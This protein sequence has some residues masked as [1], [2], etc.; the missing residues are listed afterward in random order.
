MNKAKIIEA[1]HFDEGRKAEKDMQF[2]DAAK[3][4]LLL[5]KKNPA[6]VA[7]NNRLMIVYR[8]LRELYKEAELIKRAIKAIEGAIERRQ[9]QWIDEHPDKARDTKALAMSLGLL[10]EKGLP[11]VEHEQISTWQRRLTTL[12]NKLNRPKHH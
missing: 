5:L 10:G 1:G 6:H 8:K 7:A 3:H 9:Q 12:E 2:N 11:I 4:Y